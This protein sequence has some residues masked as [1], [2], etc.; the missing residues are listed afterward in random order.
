MCFPLVGLRGD[1]EGLLEALL[2]SSAAAHIDSTPGPYAVAAPPSA[3]AGA[4]RCD[5]CNMCDMC[6]M[7][8]LCDMQHSNWCFLFLCCNA[9]LHNFELYGVVGKMLHEHTCVTERVWVYGYVVSAGW[10]G[11]D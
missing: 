1:W 3:T 4:L 8:E 10:D 9:L 11:R 7:C 2:S 6:D 5:L